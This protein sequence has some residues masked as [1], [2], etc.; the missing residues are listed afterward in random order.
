MRCDADSVWIAVFMGPREYGE[1]I[2]ETTNI[3]DNEALIPEDVA[4]IKAGD[5]LF[6][7]LLFFLVY[8]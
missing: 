2:R 1:G 3:L 7:W 4:L 5:P 6:S 8:S